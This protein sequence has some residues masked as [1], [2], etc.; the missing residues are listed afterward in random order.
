ML[1]ASMLQRIDLYF[2]VYQVNY[3]KLNNSRVYW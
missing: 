2:K 1:K 3:L